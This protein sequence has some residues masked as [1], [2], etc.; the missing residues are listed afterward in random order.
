MKDK[1]GIPILPGCVIRFEESA[2]HTIVTGTIEKRNGMLGYV[3]NKIGKWEGPIA[4]MAA[5]KIE[6][7]DAK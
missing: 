7:I 3:D 5:Y 6:V 1:N 2:Y 4:P